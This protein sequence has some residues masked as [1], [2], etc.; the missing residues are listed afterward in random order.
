MFI[1]TI[2]TLMMLL[3]QIQCRM[4]AYAVLYG[5]LSTTGYGIVTFIQDDA[6]SPVRI[7]GTV[8]GL[9]VSSAHVR[10]QNKK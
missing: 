8:S 2:V 7:G 10:G 3:N 5:D 9:N 1:L 4:T 6:N